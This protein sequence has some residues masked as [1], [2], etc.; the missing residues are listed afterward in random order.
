MLQINRASGRVVSQR[1]LPCSKSCHAPVICKSPTHC[2]H[3]LTFA[4]R[5]STLDV[6]VDPRTERI[7]IFIMAVDP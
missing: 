2:I 3:R 1:P 6:K 5:R 4:A 7:K